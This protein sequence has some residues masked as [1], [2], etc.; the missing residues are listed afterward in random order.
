MSTGA[1]VVAR[2]F[3][4]RRGLVMGVVGG[5]MSAGQLVVIPLAAALTFWFG[6]RTSTSP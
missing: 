5:A 4:A 2:W 1:A 6:W 3:E